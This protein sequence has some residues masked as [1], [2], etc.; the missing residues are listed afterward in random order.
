MKR[1][2]TILIGLTFAFAACGKKPNDKQEPAPTSGSTTAG[3]ATAGSDTAG[4]GAVVATGS[5]GSAAGSGS[6]A[7]D[8]EVPTE[9]DF[10]VD[11]TAKITD[12]NLEAEVK[13]L[14]AQLAQ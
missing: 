14:E 10:E 8:V 3:S 5:N 4:S 1:M 2:S 13:A 9:A 12:K 11:A 6:A 7:D